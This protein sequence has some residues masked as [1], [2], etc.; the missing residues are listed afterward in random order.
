MT[1]PEQ[2]DGSAVTHSHPGSGYGATVR[3]ETGSGLP[4]RCAMGSYV[5]RRRRRRP[6]VTELHRV[7][8]RDPGRPLPDD[9]PRPA[10]V[11]YASCLRAGP[12]GA[13]VRD[14]AAD[15]GL[16]LGTVVV[17][18]GL[19]REAALVADVPPVRVDRDLLERVLAGLYRL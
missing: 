4:N 15:V 17:L 7:R 10:A 13:R 9:L 11:L 16:P 6:P 14:L 8:V 2:R 1:L 19:L 18:V 3:W 12:D 5:G